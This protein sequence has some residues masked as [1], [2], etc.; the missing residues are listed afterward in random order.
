MVKITSIIVLV[1]HL[2]TAVAVNVILNAC[3]SYGILASLYRD[4]TYQDL[5]YLDL[6]VKI[7]VILVRQYD[8]SREILEEINKG[9]FVILSDR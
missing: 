7:Y 3:G 4:L 9:Y 1:S 8:V 2:P 6:E 5:G